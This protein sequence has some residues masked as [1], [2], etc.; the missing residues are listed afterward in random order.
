[1]GA[2]IGSPRI[3][4][5]LLTLVLLAA[6]LPGEDNGGASLEGLRG[7][8]EQGKYAEAEE[9]ARALLA[10]VESTHGPTSA[11]A[12]DALDVLVESRWRQG[13][14]GEPET[15]ELAQRAIEIKTEVLGSDHA[16][17]AESLN[18]LAVISFF[19][20]DYDAAGSLWERAVEIRE[21]TLAPDDP[22]LAQTLNN[23]ANLLQTIGD[24]D[25]A[26]PLYE[27]ALE[28]RK[29]AL[30]PESAR[31]ADSLSNLGVLVASMGD[32]TRARSLL[33]EAIAIKK[34]AL[35]PEHPKVASS[36]NSLAYVLD[37]IGD[38]EGER[39]LLEEAMRIWEATLGPD[40]PRVAATLNNIAEIERRTGEFD[41][42]L[43]HYRRSLAISENALGP[44]HPR[45]ALGLDNLADLF[46]QTGEHAEARRLYE[47]S[48]EIKEKAYGE[49]HPEVAESLTSLAILLSETGKLDEAGPLLE[50]AVEI[51]EKTL[52]P[53]HPDVA[54]SLIGLATLFT[55]TGDTSAALD[56]A[57]ASE[58]IARDHL[59]LTGRSLSE[60]Q[61]LR[62]ASVRHKGLDLALT[63]AEESPDAASRR[64][65]LDSLTRSRA[66]VLDEM[67]G[68]Q[69]SV[70]LSSDPEIA[71]L[72]AELASARARLANLT[73]SG[74]D[75]MDLETYQKLVDEAREEKEQAESKL[76]GASVAFARE[77]ERGRLGLDEV[78]ASLPPA[79]ALVSFVVH[80]RTT[81]VESD[82]PVPDEGQES[83]GAEEEDRI[84]IEVEPYYLALVLREGHSDVASVP[85]ATVDDIEN[86]V[87]RWKKE[88]VSA[89]RRRR[90][91]EETEKRYRQAA[92]ELRQAVWDPL[93]P[94][95]SGT[96]RVFIVPD[97]ALNLVSFAAL[98][99]GENAYLI[100]E[101]PTL[102]Y[103]SAERDLVPTF[104]SERHGTGLLAL[105]GPDYD[106]ESIFAAGV[107]GTGS[108]PTDPGEDNGL[109][110]SCGSFDSLRFDP[111]QAAAIEAEEIVAL[112]E[113]AGAG[114]ETEQ[115]GLVHLAGAEAS[116]AAIK[117]AAPGKQV[118]HLA[119]H[120][121]FLGGE[122]ASGS[123]R[124]RGSRGLKLV[125]EPDPA[126]ITGV[127]PLLL[128]GLAL[129]GA[130]HRG[131]A[132]EGEEDGILTAEE[133]AS[134]DLS[135]VE[136]AVLSACDT[137]VGE[138]QAGE[139]VFGLRR[140]MQVAGVRTLIMSLWPVDDEA[141]RRWMRALYRGRLFYQLDSAEAVRG[142]SVSVIEQRRE[143]GESTHPFY[144]AAFVAAGDWR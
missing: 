130:N 53:A 29:Q 122:C 135:G 120:G 140:A 132:A 127:S 103:L 50:R 114:Q 18:N 15:R 88:A 141:T 110:S 37:V 23:L 51:R 3:V 57:L 92:Q 43:G 11:E 125:E 22:R 123:E 13:K 61:A 12:A 42:A 84:S 136:W 16:L 65:V 90:S 54:E 80:D 78:V 52:G 56:L 20:G 124:I 133:I 74:L 105:G 143:A 8:V 118:L 4:A 55:A 104:D 2:K 89:A 85:L 95:L 144:W 75:N 39:P 9:G 36:M 112:W 93:T 58:R 126:P 7:L 6:P 115:A 129:A 79:S 137:G 134:L 10:E 73:V 35:G 98:P 139:G 86:R 64:R 83:T 142:A 66:V 97:G 71:R 26:L 45:V 131:L 17:V 69:R 77:R 24:Y 62:Y 121:F 34:K 87:E 19:I 67:A 33:E 28:I 128:S 82:H 41:A 96:E 119:T 27:R 70:T 68:R 116:E 63:L 94:H 21:R 59:R 106:D 30:G 91:P 60:K 49:L 117:T 1:M 102:H 138:I 76:A 109:R 14:F 44:D 100:E 5:G 32:Y 25:A 47:R 99:V 72:A 81:V 31:V 38:Y 48:L 108:S 113:E 101:G 40:H 46:K 111:L 107:V